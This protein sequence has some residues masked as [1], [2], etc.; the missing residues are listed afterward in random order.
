MLEDV[1]RQF[2]ANEYNLINRNCNHFC[3]AFTMQLLDKKLP[4]YINRAAKFGNYFSCF[5]PSSI[6]GLNPVPSDGGSTNMNST[7]G[8]TAD[9]SQSVDLLNSSRGAFSGKGYTISDYE[10]D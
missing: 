10:L 8:S 4:S 1:K 9:L 5:L 3:E 7:N 2:K 6:K